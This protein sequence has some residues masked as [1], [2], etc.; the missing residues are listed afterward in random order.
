MSVIIL[1]VG[2]FFSYQVHSNTGRGRPPPVWP[3]DDD[4]TVASAG[5]AQPDGV[6]AGYLFGVLCSP[7]QL[8]F[9]IQQHSLLIRR[10]MTLHYNVGT[11]FSVQ[12]DLKSYQ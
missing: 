5:I 2:I 3:A 10:C 1:L 7:N 4:R 6:C 12:Y 11:M 8:Y 9:P